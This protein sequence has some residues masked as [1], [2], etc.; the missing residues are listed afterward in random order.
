M[1]NLPSRGTV[2]VPTGGPAKTGR[3]PLA[4]RGDAQFGDLAPGD[5]RP[6]TKRS[7]VR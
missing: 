1:L 2:N 4:L 6:G 5:H 3:F 7:I